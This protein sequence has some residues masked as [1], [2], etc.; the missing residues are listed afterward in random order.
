MQIKQQKFMRYYKF[1]GNYHEKMWLKLDIGN[2]VCS[3]VSNNDTSK[4]NFV[5]NWVSN[6]KALKNIN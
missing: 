1:K 4:G 5:T 6:K 2:N 3:Y